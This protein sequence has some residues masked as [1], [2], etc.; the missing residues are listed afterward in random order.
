MIQQVPQAPVQEKSAP[1]LPIEQ[2]EAPAK[3]VAP[4]IRF[5]VNQL[6]VTGQTRFSEAELVAATGFK[7]GSEL[8][9]ADLRAF[10]SQITAFY[11]LA[12]YFVAQA[13]LPPQEIKGGVVTIA[14]IEGRY[15]KISLQNQTNVSD[16]VF[17]RVLDGLNEGD[18]VVIDP[19]ERRLLL[20]SDIPGV[21][22]KSTLSP[23]AAVGTSDLTVDTTLEPRVNGSLE[24]DNAGNPY[25][26]TNRVGATVNL[27][28]PFG[29]G[30]VL[31]ARFLTSRLPDTSGAMDYGRVFYQAQVW[32][33]TVGVAYTTFDYR[34]G[35]QF[36]SLDASG[37]EQIASLYGSYP[38]I[39]SYN[40]NLYALLDYDHRIFQDKIGATSSTIDKQADVL[41]AGLSGNSHDDFGSG[42]WNAY[43]LTGTFG[44]L[45]IQSP[46]AR[47]ADATTA[48]TNG[49]YGK[50][51]YSASRLQHVI[52]PLSL[53]GAIRGQFATNNL[54]ISEKMEL[55]GAQ[56]VRAYPEGEAYGDEGYIA[57]L[58]ARLLLPRWVESLPGEMQLVSF[59]DTGSV[60]FDKSPWAP[61]PNEATRSGVGAGLTWVA[62]NNFTA[63]VFYARELG[64]RATSAPDPGHG[65][66]WVQLAKYF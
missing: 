36:S 37:S 15:G 14:V 13:Y 53:F 16:R 55:G 46:L 21:A 47:A 42:G 12:G 52:G 7:P 45:D 62:P 4:G 35:E 23:G 63:S 18:P 38:L 51:S 61:G 26:G 41:I 48:R 11:N 29:Y 30:D 56:G 27:N 60:T 54:D 32:D 43:S 39:R 31:G 25:T 24:Y 58:E 65:R 44:N 50:L 1:N 20:I 8:D 28:E 57:T 19:L 49:T 9:L 33:A 10:A 40:D 2:R 5:V 17:E 59:V 3:P 64:P 66:F 6:H 22:V 34:L